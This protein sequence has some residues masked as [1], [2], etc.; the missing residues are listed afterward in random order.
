MG[1][2]GVGGAGICVCFLNGD[3]ET[4][5]LLRTCLKLE[6][7]RRTTLGPC[8]RTGESR[9]AILKGEVMDPELEEEG[10]EIAA[11]E[12]QPMPDSRRMEDF[13]GSVV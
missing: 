3:M 10:I 12:A 13:I 7:V 1:R 9:F 11:G 8:W 4:R 5:L 6:E 2:E